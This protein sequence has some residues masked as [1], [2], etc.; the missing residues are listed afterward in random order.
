MDGGLDLKKN[1]ALIGAHGPTG[2]G[3]AKA[4]KSGPTGSLFVITDK[5][6]VF[7]TVHSATRVEGIQFYYPEQTWTD[8]SKIIRYPT[9]IQVSQTDNA[10]GVTLRDLS[11]Y[12]EY[13]AMDFR[14]QGACEQIL[15]ENCYGYP[16]SGQFIAIDKCYDI[17]RI[18]HCHVNPANQREFGR[19]FAKAVVDRVV[20]NQTYTYWV[21]RTD[22]AVFM[23]LFTFGNYG[24]IY[25]GPSTYGQFTNFNFDCVA[26][27]IYQA[28]TKT[29]MIAQGGIIANLGTK[30]EDIHPVYVIGSGHTSLTNI[31][32]FSGQNGALTCLGA[33]YD[34][35]TLEGT[36]YST[37]AMYGCRLR[38]YTSDS[39]ITVHN[40]CASLRATDCVDKEGNF[41]DRIVDPSAEYEPGTITMMDNCDATAGWTTQLNGATV[42]L[43]TQHQQE[44]SGCISVTAGSGGVIFQKV[45]DTPVD[46]KVGK[47]GGH[48]KFRL[49]ISDLSAF[50]LNGE[51]AVEVTSGGTCDDH[52][53]AWH[54]K[55]L[56]LKT[57]WNDLDLRLDAAGITGGSPDLTAMNYIRIYQLAITK[58]VTVKLDD[59]KFCQE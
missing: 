6:N 14:P 34:F 33:S 54:I 18:L 51:G 9:T 22:N 25:L 39:P 29:W 30:V 10:Q 15:F 42:Q 4:D 8:P 37:V 26:I 55:N 7:L 44:G 11:F 19:S 16:L 31:E 20:A 57:G 52:E 49:Y 28:S 46:T 5:S 40:P 1:V 17:P 47:K 21:D 2:R 23:D 3:T 38:S 53:F 59:V 48:F 50:D 43:D 32:C 35:I 12:G 58:N 36:D 27:G 13:F 56:N 24:G 41:F 45:F